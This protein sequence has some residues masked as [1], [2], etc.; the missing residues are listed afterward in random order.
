MREGESREGNE[1]MMDGV[2]IHRIFCQKSYAQSVCARR[3]M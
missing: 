3:S 1:R 2:D